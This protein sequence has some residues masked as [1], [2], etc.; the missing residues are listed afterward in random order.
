MTPQRTS[1]IIPALV[2]ALLPLGCEA[3]PGQTGDPD[4]DFKTMPK[5]PFWSIAI[6]DGQRIPARYTADGKDVSPPM[7][8]RYWGWRS[9]GRNGVCG[10]RTTGCALPAP[11]GS[12]LDRGARKT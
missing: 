12:S 2:L 5:V 10:R 8:W 1:A 4:D 7:R 11:T 9:T 6:K 3:G